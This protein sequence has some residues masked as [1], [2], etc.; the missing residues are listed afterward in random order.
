MLADTAIFIIFFSFV[1]LAEPA[2]LHIAGFSDVLAETAIWG[3]VLHT[4]ATVH[5]N[6]WLV[7]TKKQL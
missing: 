1:T 6:V 5:P 7:Q 2:A 3:S 4:V